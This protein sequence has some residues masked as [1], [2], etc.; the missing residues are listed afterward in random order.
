LADDEA[1][2]LRKV[3]V[4][5]CHR[6][7]VLRREPEELRAVLR[8]RRIIEDDERFGTLAGG[9]LQDS[10]EVARTPYGKGQKRQPQLGTH[11]FYLCEI[12]LGGRI[13][14]VHEHADTREAWEDLFEDLQPLEA[15]IV[16]VKT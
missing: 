15:E 8:D 9:G 14:R 13:V 5:R 1:A 4:D 6:Q 7:R 16:G 10:R 3:L 11:L 12:K 2:G